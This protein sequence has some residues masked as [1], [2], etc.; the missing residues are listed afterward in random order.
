M[1]YYG[2]QM[3]AS[4]LERQVSK[5]GITYQELAD[6][7][8]MSETSIDRWFKGAH[9]P[10]LANLIML[11]EVFGNCQGR[12]PQQLVFEALMNVSEMV[13]AQN[14]WKKKNGLV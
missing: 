4:W 13:H 3:L 7:T 2:N 9:P 8:G 11:C 10:K 5:S 14:R 1:K 12:S 6:L